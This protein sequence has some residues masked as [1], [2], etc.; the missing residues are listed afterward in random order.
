MTPLERAGSSILFLYTLIWLSGPLF[1]QSQE[2]INN[3]GYLVSSNHTFIRQHNIHTHFVPASIIKLATALA[4]LE[5]LGA[6]FRYQTKFYLDEQNALYIQGF[7]DP[8]LTSEH[9]AEI[10]HAL[11]RK[12]IKEIKKIIIDGSSFA[13]TRPVDGSE[14]SHNPYDVPNGAIAVNFNTLAIQKNRDLS[15]SSGEPQTPL[16]A[17]TTEIGSYLEPGHRRVNVNAFPSSGTLDNSSRY[18]GEL[19]A[20]FLNKKGVD[21]VTSITTGM[22][23]DRCKLVYIFT[24]PRELQDILRECLKY[25]NNF[26]ANQVF[27]SSGAL[28]Y[29]YPATWLK[30]QRALRDTLVDILGTTAQNVTIVEGAGLSRNS[31]VTPLFIYRVLLA[32]KPYRLLLP[33]QSGIRIKSGTL[34]DVYCYAG[35]FDPLGTADPFVIMLNQTENTRDKVL[36]LLKKS[37]L[38]YKDQG[39][40]PRHP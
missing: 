26:I 20:A 23:S 21:T 25:S 36:D 12:G 15:V 14:G 11:Q 19:F 30:A 6:S 37:Y 9:I 31:S 24:N 8:F 38:D 18:V 13:L 10:A 2:I 27:L 35:Y 28:L 33:D 29:G 3:G 40:V 5:T 34:T 16:I 22:V 17:L 32:L 4:A 1:C 39:G 7:G